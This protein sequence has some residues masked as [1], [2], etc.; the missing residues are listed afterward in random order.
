MKAKLIVFLLIAIAPVYSFGQGC[1]TIFSEDGDKF[2]LTLNS[3]QQNSVPQAN[4][5]VDGLSSDFY[6]AKITFADPT[7]PA[8]TKNM[9]TKDA[10]TGEF[11]EMTFK[12]KKT[13]D[14]ELKLRYFGATPIPASYN[15]P[16]DMYVAH[17][18]QP[19]PG[20]V[21]QSSTQTTTVT[22][23]NPASTS[24]SVNAGG[25]NMNVNVNDPNGGAGVNMNVNMNDPN[26][27]TSVTQTTTTRT[28]TTTTDGG[29]SNAAPAAA[30]CNYPM[31]FSTFNGAKQAIGNSSFE[32]TRLST[33]KTVL[34]SN[35]ISTDQV[36]EICK[37]FGTDESKLS[38]AKAAYAKTTDKNNYFKVGNVFTFD[39]SKTELNNFLSK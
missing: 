36:V 35:C 17:F 37:L 28:T 4:V 22:S 5:R 25:L 24:V 15:P 18:G 34:K 29:Y 12:I 33:A 1:I 30:G 20:V 32:D 39:A 23:V 9:P 31:D 14:G 10:A 21:T 38:F 3:I 19:S 7:K 11:M 2:Y 13:K 26:M 16:A 8:I 27:N 6:Q